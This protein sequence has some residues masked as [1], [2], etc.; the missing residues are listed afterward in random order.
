MKPREDARPDSRAECVRRVA[1]AWREADV[2]GVVLRGYENLPRVGNDL[3]VLVPADRRTTAESLLLIAAG[4]AGLRRYLRVEKAAASPIRH[5]FVNLRSR[6]S[7]IVDMFTDLNWEGVR[8]LD[9][10]D[11]LSRRRDGE[12]FDVPHPAHEAA[13]SLLS[14]LLYGSPI[15]DP[16]RERLRMLRAADP[17]EF[18]RCLTASVGVDLARVLDGKVRD[19]RLGV[20]PVVTRRLRR[21]L[22]LRSLVH[23]PFG[24]LGGLGRQAKRLLTRVARPAG[25]FVVLVGADGAGKSTIAPLLCERLARRMG[26]GDPMHFHWKPLE[27]LPTG[28]ATEVVDPHGRP[29]R[30]GALSGLFFLRHWFDFVVGSW[31][32]VFPRLV[33]GTVVV[34]ERYYDD[35]LLDPVRYRLTQPRGLGRALRWTVVRPDV[36]LCLVAAAETLQA[37]K[38][39]VGVEVSRAQTAAIE[40][41]AAV[42]PGA[43]IVDAGRP[44][45]EV[46]DA[47]E[48]AV[49][50]ALVDREERRAGGTLAARARAGDA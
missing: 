37:R 8:F 34:G 48:G 49:L 45:D 42:T 13:V 21:A 33:R 47:C 11:V 41:F 16:R 23:R 36:F 50:G 25:A 3:D 27:S 14:K 7:L 30:T 35:M 29:V 10:A 26:G 43:R 39:E 32:R 9:A 46:L 12:F 24:L 31:L 1:A 6:D 17:E 40:R 20:T 38:R 19:G 44:L 22:I 15:P 18:L 4:G 2:D 28:V 5:G